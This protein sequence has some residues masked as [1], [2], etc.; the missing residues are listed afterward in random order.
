MWEVVKKGPIKIMKVVAE[1]HPPSEIGPD[2]K[3]VEKEGGA[4][5][6]F[7]VENLHIEFTLKISLLIIWIVLLAM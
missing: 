2:G 7:Y 5:E 1:N 4:V 3:P 6:D